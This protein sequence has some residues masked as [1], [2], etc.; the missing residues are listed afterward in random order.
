MTKVLGFYKKDAMSWDDFANEAKFLIY[1]QVPVV[2]LK[3]L[4][5]LRSKRLE[6]MLDRNEE[7]GFGNGYLCAI[8]EIIE[9]ANK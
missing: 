1:K 6:E 5:K 4:E 2:S 7:R 3:W 9:E 8:D